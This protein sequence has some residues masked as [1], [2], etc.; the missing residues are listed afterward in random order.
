M[1][2]CFQY[3]NINL[4]CCD[5]N[6][7]FD[8]C[9]EL[10]RPYDF[11]GRANRNG[12]HTY[13][14][15]QMV[16]E[17]LT[18]YSIYNK[19]VPVVLP[20]LYCIGIQLDETSRINVFMRTF[21][22][23]S[24]FLQTFYDRYIS[25]MIKNG[26]IFSVIYTYDLR[27]FYLNHNQ[28]KESFQDL[29]T[30][31]GD[32]AY[33]HFN[34]FEFR[35]MKVYSNLPSEKIYI[36]SKGE[37]DNTSIYSEKIK[38]PTTKLS[39]TYYNYMNFRIN[40]LFNFLQYMLLVH[41]N[42]RPQDEGNLANIPITMI[43][44]IKNKMRRFC[45][46]RFTDIRLHLVN[47]N[48]LEELDLL[49][50]LLSGGICSYSDKF[51][52]KVVENVD[53]FDI[54]S[55]YPD[56]VYS[57]DRFPKKFIT[58]YE[59]LDCKT[60]YNMIKNYAVYGYVTLKGVV[61]RENCPYIKLTNL[62]LNG[63]H[64][65][66]IEFVDAKYLKS[67]DYLTIALTDCD[68]ELLHNFYE[69]Q[70][71]TVHHVYQYE[72][73]FLPNELC[74]CLTTLF[75]NKC[76]NAESFYGSLDKVGVNAV[77]G[78]LDIKPDKVFASFDGEN[79]SSRVPTKDERIDAL[80]KYNENIDKGEAISCYQWGIYVA[81]IVRMRLSYIIKKAVDLGI[82]IYSDT[83]SCIVKHNREFSEFIY[84]YNSKVFKY[85]NSLN[86]SK[87]CD[88]ICK[89]PIKNSNKFKWKIMGTFEAKRGIS[90]FK[91]IARK[92][93][94]YLTSK[95]VGSDE[96]NNFVY[97]NEMTFKLAGV[98]IN[99]VRDYFYFNSK[100]YDEM[101]ELFS[102]DLVIPK[103]K[104]ALTKIENIHCTIKD[105]Q[106]IEY[107]YNCAKN[108]FK[109]FNDFSFKRLKENDFGGLI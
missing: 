14:N 70:L 44:Y 94:I 84:N 51:V 28:Y 21:E 79:I 86:R 42:N 69:F 8:N 100:N 22:E 12:Y 6:S 3:D 35:C 27:M 32:P 24:D 16:L 75:I 60:Y 76:L 41:K 77:Y 74:E 56:A 43:R 91:V 57:S 5:T 48:S 17:V 15:L 46:N 9:D 89:I 20:Y 109:V 78:L 59:E 99:K 63:N 65:V 67:A 31:N 45:Y 107:D 73:G 53:I 36:N 68:F 39:K 71:G 87:K 102:P 40:C 95:V 10:F 19:E 37:P 13:C 2:D 18:T 23:L 80:S 90:K 98:S 64:G 33:F 82:W 103:V 96:S 81:A 50:N 55:A 62:S 61:H 1:F 29:F 52:N 85:R 72:R 11:C 93:Y 92:E 4:I 105:Y 58:Y 26:N 54:T 104:P 38:T 101:F 88:F 7:F 30:V 25:C 97:E 106:G 47:I 34:G 66:N 49:N 83:D 108:Y